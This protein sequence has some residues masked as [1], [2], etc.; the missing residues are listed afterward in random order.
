MKSGARAV[1]VTLPTPE[2]KNDTADGGVRTLDPRLRSSRDPRLPPS[3]RARPNWQATGHRPPVRGRQGPRGS[4]GGRPPGGGQVSQEGLPY[5]CPSAPLV[6]REAVARVRY[7]DLQ[8]IELVMAI[9]IHRH[10]QPSRLVWSVYIQVR[11]RAF[12]A[13]RVDSAVS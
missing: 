10:E 2:P 1:S 7:D 9:V 11:D 6:P 13:F 5:S 3:G 8:P 12:E 4:N